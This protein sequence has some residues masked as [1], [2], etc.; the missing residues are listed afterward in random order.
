MDA[1]EHICKGFVGKLLTDLEGLAMKEAIQEYTGK[2][3]GS[4][5]F[6]GSNPIGGIWTTPDVGVANACVM[7]A[8]FEIRDH[9]LSVVDL[10]TSI[11]IGT[12]P[13]KIHQPAA[14]R[15]NTRLSRVAAK[16]S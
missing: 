7:P 8:A 4:T 5:C 3:L 14:C 2:E 1:N 11:L 13:S 12:N 9:C 10:I 16:Y 6:R 15:L